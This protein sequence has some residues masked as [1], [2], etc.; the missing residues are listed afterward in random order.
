MKPF[1]VW[2]MFTV[3]VV[4][5]CGGDYRR[6]PVASSGVRKATAHVQA[7]ADGLTVEQRNVTKRLKVDNAPGSL[8]HLYVISAYSGQVLIYSTVD[9]KVTSSGK[10]LTPSSVAA[11]DS[12]YTGGIP[13]EI[14][15]RTLHT[16][17]VL[18]DDG[19]YGSSVEYLYWFDAAGRYHQHYIQGGQILHISDQPIAVK[20]VVMNMELTEPQAGK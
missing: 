16:P 2:A 4:T 9:G 8:K 6:E 10:R 12:Q 19:T 17:E 14:G 5:A 7:G 20:S 13:V 18:Q 15:N 3:A 11:S 1:H